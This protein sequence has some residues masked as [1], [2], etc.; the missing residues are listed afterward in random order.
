MNFFSH[1]LL[2]A[3]TGRGPRFVLGSML[4][5]LVNM[6][7]VRMPQLDEPE[8]RAGVAHHELVDRLF[9]PLPRTVRLMDAL[10]ARLRARG[11]SGGA[12]DAVGH[13]GFE[14]L[15]D[16]YLWSEG[17]PLEAYQQAFAEV[18][19]LGNCVPQEL[20]SK[21]QQL[22]Q[23]VMQVPL[24]AAYGR[25]SFVTEV[26]QRILQGYPSLALSA[27]MVPHV[28]AELQQAQRGLVQEALPLWSELRALLSA[29]GAEVNG[30]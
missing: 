11:V 4:P 16:G 30:Q 1:A 26:L 17:F 18:D 8:L 6:V 24:P 13:V 10:A 5:D 25:P 29:Q 14:L 23:R 27:A 15:L 9:H 3:E 28:T 19:M 7:G 21:L 12:P 20:G 2:A 22:R